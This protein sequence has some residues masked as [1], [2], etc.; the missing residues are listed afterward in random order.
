MIL[1]WGLLFFLVTCLVDGLG[2]NESLLSVFILARHGERYPCHIL[3]HPGYPK[4]FMKM[5]CQLT[6]TGAR[7]HFELGRFIGRRYSSLL[8][9]KGF[10]RNDVHIRSTG[11]ERTILSATYF[12][13]GLDSSKEVKLPVLPAV[14]SS[15]KRHDYLLK[16]SYPCSAFDKLYEKALTSNLTRD[17]INRMRGLFDDLNNFTEFNFESDSLHKYLPKLWDLCESIHAWDKL[18]RDTKGESLPFTSDLAS[19]CHRA[20]SFR[21]QLLFSS[22][23]QTFFRGGPLW[24]HVLLTLK[25]RISPGEK[26]ILP[27]EIA[28]IDALD[29]PIVSDSRLFAYFAHDS[30]LTA[31]LSHL[32]AFNNILPPY[33]S[34]V[35]V[36][37]HRL[38]HGELALRFFY[39][40]ESKLSPSQLIP[41]TTEL[42]GGKG[43]YWCPLEVL[44]DRL[45]GKAA[46]DMENACTADET[47]SSSISLAASA[48]AASILF[49]FVLPIGFIIRVLLCLISILLTYRFL[50]PIV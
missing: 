44:E 24:R 1:Q 14:F 16:M 18:E 42:C 50:F 12:G 9:W 41:L 10:K 38:V 43:A 21:Q 20:L 22:P 3:R 39:H 28:D 8:T 23:A 27:L 31:F 4:E 34:A 25:S 46:T 7:Q 37:L 29:I 26:N 49:A 40:N 47:S 5:R 6:E 32:G 36:E 11:T 30:T 48:L 15:P 19:A 13:L 33:A 35:I 45:H 17:F 2:G